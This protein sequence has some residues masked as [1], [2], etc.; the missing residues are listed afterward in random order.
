M[1]ILSKE[2]KSDLGKIKDIR[3][4]FAHNVVGLSFMQ[5][6]VSDVCLSLGT[7]F[8]QDIS[9]PFLAKTRYVMTCLHYWNK[10]GRLWE[11]ETP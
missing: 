3:N 1:N 9:P 8:I 4:A 2:E 11:Q 7:S 5:T 6:E 10:L